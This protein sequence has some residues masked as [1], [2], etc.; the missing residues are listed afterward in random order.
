VDE[1]AK[2][3]QWVARL[4][5]GLFS[6]DALPHSLLNLT[7]AR[8][9]DRISSP[10]WANF[11]VPD[12]LIRIVHIDSR[13][14]IPHPG[15]QRFFNFTPHRLHG[16]QPDSYRSSVSRVTVRSRGRAAKTSI[17]AQAFAGVRP[18]K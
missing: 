13:R 10:I 6:S 4:S 15:G 8:H 7:S 5:G 14:V 3:E 16:R 18:R 11:S 12:L 9:R 2:G 17:P 1:I